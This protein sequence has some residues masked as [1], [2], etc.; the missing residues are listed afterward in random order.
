MAR[1][2]E[3]LAHNLTD[4]IT[5]LP[6]AISE[7]KII[8]E[9]ERL[10]IDRW[11]NVVDDAKRTI[12]GFMA[13]EYGKS[14][15]INARGFDYIW[16]TNYFLYTDF[17]RSYCG[18]RQ[19]DIPGGTKCKKYAEDLL[20]GRDVSPPYDCPRPDTETEIAGKVNELCLAGCAFLLLH[21]YAHAQLDHGQ[22]TSELSEARHLGSLDYRTKEQQNRLESLRHNIVSR[23]VEADTRAMDIM[24]TSSN[25]PE[26]RLYSRALG[27][28]S[29]MLCMCYLYKTV[30]MRD[31][32]H[33]PMYERIKRLLDKLSGVLGNDNKY[34]KACFYFAS[35]GLASYLEHRGKPCAEYNGA[36][37]I[38]AF[39]LVLAHFD[40]LVN[41]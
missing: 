9:M 24:F 12:Q 21:E 6:G 41:K 29:T 36:C 38:E 19:N 31:P 14:V 34:V 8:A 33:P 10:G 13:Y 27:V 37:P 11:I 35:A 40:S 32:E 20:D 26:Q 4:Y 5:Y 2:I 1:F 25:E 28:V 18:S 17:T 22:F 30:G 7:K 39:D 15:T 23:E 16:S 3:I